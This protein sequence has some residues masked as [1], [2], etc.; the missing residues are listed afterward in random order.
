MDA[1][2]GQTEFVRFENV[3]YFD[4][5]RTSYNSW[6]M[7][8]D[9]CPDDPTVQ[10]IDARIANITGF[11]YQNMEYYQIL[12]YAPKQEYQAHSDWIELQA[13]Q[14]SVRLLP[15]LLASAHRLCC[16]QGQCFRSAL[17]CYFGRSKRS[18]HWPIIWPQAKHFW[19]KMASKKALLLCLQVCNIRSWLLAMVNHPLPLIRC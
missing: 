14:P 9:D 16:C 15:R 19:L 8:P 7:A 6:C 12:R 18:L 1:I 10:S 5:G 17:C 13:G 4:E 3:Y 11:S 2:R